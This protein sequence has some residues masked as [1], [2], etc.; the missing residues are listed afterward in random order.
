MAGT[1]PKAKG[2]ARPPAFG[3]VRNTAGFEDAPWH[4]GRQQT[5]QAIPREVAHSTRR[6]GLASTLC[7]QDGVTPRDDLSLCERQIVAAQII[8]ERNCQYKNRGWYWR[9][10]STSFRWPTS[11]TAD[12][13]SAEQI[14]DLWPRDRDGYLVRMQPQSNFHRSLMVRHLDEQLTEEDIATIYGRR[15]GPLVFISYGRWAPH[16]IDA[17]GRPRQ[18]IMLT[19]EEDDGAIK[20]ILANNG[21]PANPSR[22]RAEPAQVTLSTVDHVLTRGRTEGRHNGVRYGLDECQPGGGG[23]ASSVPWRDEENRLQYPDYDFYNRK[24]A[25]GDDSQLPKMSRFRGYCDES[26]IPEYES[27]QGTIPRGRSLYA[28]S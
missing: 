14:L 28:P 12:K 7:G 19:F 18:F 20:S 22:P 13:V 26:W 21:L 24:V 6:F 27:S 17:I 1:T 16:R 9:P 15:F 4:H 5:T 3:D 11:I 25:R 10:Q 8:V 23:Q 2:Q